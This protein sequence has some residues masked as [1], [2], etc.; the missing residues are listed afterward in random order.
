MHTQFM[1]PFLA[2]FQTSNESLFNLPELALSHMTINRKEQNERGNQFN[3]VLP[4]EQRP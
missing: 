1:L 4:G 3:Y 2:T